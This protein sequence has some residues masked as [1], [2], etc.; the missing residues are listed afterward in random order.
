M[1]PTHLAVISGQSI[2]FFIMDPQREFQLG[3]WQVTPLRGVIH[4]PEGTR[5]ITPKAMDVLLCMAKRPGDVV[6]RETFLQEVWDGR[7]FSDEPLNKCIAELRRK[8]GDKGDSRKYIETI[9]KRGYRLVAKLTVTGT[10]PDEATPAV[11]SGPARL[12]AVT[13]VAALVLVGAWTLFKNDRPADNVSIAVLPFDNLSGEDKAY[14]AD[15][16]HEEL[17]SQ[18]TQSEFF[19]VR[20]GTSTLQYRNSD[21]PLPTIAGELNVDAV[22][23]GS[24][25]HDGDRIRVTAQLIQAD[26]DEHLWAGNIEKSLSVAE[27][28]AIQEEIARE[29]AAALR[30]T[31]QAGNGKSEAALPTES[32]EAYEN[33]MLGKYH[34]RRKLPGDI[35]KSVSNFEAAVSLDPA[36]ADAWDWLAYAYNHA[37]TDVGYLSPD[38]A[39]PKARSAALRALELEPELA[40]AVSILGYIRAIY[41]RD[42]VGAEADLKR[43]T[44]LDPN[45]SGTVWSLAHVYSMLGRH[46]EAIQ[47]TREF[48]AR[49]PEAGRRHSEIA[50]RLMDAKRFDAALDALDA[51]LANGAEPA[52]V[53][54]ARGVALVGL[55]R[56]AEAVEQFE[57]AVFG[58]QRDAATIARLAFAYGKLGRIDEATTLLQELQHRAETEY[59][60]GT[61]LATAYLGV[62]QIN[63]AIAHLELAAAG[64]GREAL[65]IPNDLFYAE[66]HARPEFQAMVASIDLPAP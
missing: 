44:Q 57:F 39:Y 24:V 31:Y 34:Y 32:I 13:A 54:D 36:F 20:S 66:L 30:V 12:V 42:W 15:G 21:L 38:E 25:R 62:G 46:D 14:F 52:Q 22:V 3:E 63:A 65:G 47:L 40:T 41:D 1:L 56:Y 43:A 8:L 60:S 19:A 5:R 7:A 6:D 49:R 53:A 58:K 48:A 33:F 64:R 18:L 17:I 59:V 16:V 4:G 45:D 27:L 51:A 35:R 10:A 11:S 2:L 61:T 28:F 50:N 26:V 55:K 9:P 37:A 29:I 23:E